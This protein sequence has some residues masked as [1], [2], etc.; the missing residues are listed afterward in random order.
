VGE[1]GRAGAEAGRR[2]G[3]G[4]KGTPAFQ[5]GPTGG[6]LELIQVGSL[7]PEGIVPAIEAVLAR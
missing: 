2:Y 5:V 7:G 1:L 3:G 4:G 6:R